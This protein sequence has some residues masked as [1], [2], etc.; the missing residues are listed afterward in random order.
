MAAFL[1]GGRR[2]EKEPRK[3]GRRER[4]RNPVTGT[5]SLASFGVCIDSDWTKNE[6]AEER[7]GGFKPGDET[8]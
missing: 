7:G 6:A 5:L 1:F 4:E 2:A 8:D 3:A